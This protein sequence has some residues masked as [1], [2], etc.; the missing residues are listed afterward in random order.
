MGLV[1]RVLAVE[2]S[3]AAPDAWLRA[4]TALA[5]LACFSLSIMASI[6]P[7]V[8]TTHHLRSGYAAFPAWTAWA[9]LNARGPTPALR[10]PEWVSSL[11]LYLAVACIVLAGL[12]FL[13]VQA[14]QEA[15]DQL[16]S[17]T[18]DRRTAASAMET[19]MSSPVL[20]SSPVLHSECELPWAVSEAIES[21]NSYVPRRL[22]HS[23]IERVRQRMLQRQAYRICLVSAARVR[24]LPLCLIL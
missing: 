16:Q 2:A 24:L 19:R 6:S 7:R 18:I 17:Y 5:C 22:R 13:C 23:E 12:Q 10:V 4:N 14:H 11:E 9:L 20:Q 3:V 8:S 15:V 1:E 21:Y